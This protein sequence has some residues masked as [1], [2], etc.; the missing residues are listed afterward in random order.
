MP[1]PAEPA[2]GGRCCLGPAG[3]YLLVL[4]ALMARIP[5]AV[6][7]SR[8][9]RH[10]TRVAEVVAEGPGVVQSADPIFRAPRGLPIHKC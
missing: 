9:V 4:V 10:S 1:R 6:P 3:A 5:F 2:R 7:V 8:S